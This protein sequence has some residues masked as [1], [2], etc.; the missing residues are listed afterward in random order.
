MRILVLTPEI[1][2]TSRMPGS[3]RVFSLCRFLSSHH[4]ISLITGSQ[5]KGRRELFSQDPS[6]GGVFDSVTYLPEEPAP[7][8]WNK[9][10]QRIRQAPY[11]T[12]EFWKPEYYAASSISYEGN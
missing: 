3:P 4:A 11:F 9:Q 7:T 5:L 8:R 2:A 1:P 6:V 12:T 10:K